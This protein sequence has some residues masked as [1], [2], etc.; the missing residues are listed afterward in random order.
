M[1]FNIEFIQFSSLGASIYRLQV[2][3]SVWLKIPRRRLEGRHKA[4]GRTT[5]WSA[6]QISLK[7]FPELSRV[8]TVLPLRLNG[9]TL[10]AHNFHIKA[11]RFRTITSVVRTVDLMHVISI[12]EAWA[13]GPWRLSSERLKFEC[14]TCLM[15]ERIWMGIHIV[16]IVAAVFPYL[17]FRKKS[18]SWSN[19]EWHLDMLL[20]RPDGYKLE[21]FEASWHRGRSGW[22]VLVVRMD[23]AWTVECPD[24]MSR[25]PDGCK[26][27]EFNCHEIR[28]ESCLKNKT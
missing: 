19:I 15:N 3:M 2:Q 5:V 13:S 6:F 16:R 20:R 24:I 21:Q 28:T 23:D 7:F 17:C 26:G 1:E 27:T 12:Y 22:K 11:W 14:S 9:R 25:R 8:Q 4:F 18:H 10:A